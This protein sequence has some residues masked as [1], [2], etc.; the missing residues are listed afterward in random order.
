MKKGISNKGHSITADCCIGLQSWYFTETV[1]KGNAF[2]ESF[3]P[4]ATFSYFLHID[5]EPPHKWRSDSRLDNEALE[6]GRKVLKS[7][8]RNAATLLWCA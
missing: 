7:I 6:A 1:P 2:S 8:T 3:T 4:L 5:K